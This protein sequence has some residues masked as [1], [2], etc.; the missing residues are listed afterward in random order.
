MDDQEVSVDL[1]DWFHVS[2]IVEECMKDLFQKV[3]VAKG[4]PEPEVE[5]RFASPRRWRFD[6]C[7]PDCKVALEVEGGIW[8]QGRHS[9]GKGMLGDMQKY[10][11]AALAGYAVFRCT[12]DQLVTA[13]TFDLISAALETRKAG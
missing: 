13:E 7:W 1:G 11:A 12:P 2:E 3:C 4:L 5:Y 6:Y 8:I 9:R 10:N